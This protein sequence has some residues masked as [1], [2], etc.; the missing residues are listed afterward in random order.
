MK[1]ILGNKV[2]EIIKAHNKHVGHST[3]D[4]EHHIENDRDVLIFCGMP[5]MSDGK[6]SYSFNLEELAHEHEIDV[7]E[8]VAC[9]KEMYNPSI[10]L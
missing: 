4:I 3:F 10:R 9:Y 5:A 8:L 6:E 7:L 2:N 1:N